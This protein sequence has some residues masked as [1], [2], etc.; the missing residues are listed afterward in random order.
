MLTPKQARNKATVD[1]CGWGKLAEK[2]IDEL[3]VEA[4]RRRCTSVTFDEGD[5]RDND[6]WGVPVPERFIEPVI[7]QY[8]EKG[9]K[10]T[11][12]KANPNADELKTRW[13]FHIPQEAK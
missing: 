7:E 11:V 2:K 3:L 4:I 10:V 13:M 1:D 12:L 8:Q 6:A 9:W 5:L